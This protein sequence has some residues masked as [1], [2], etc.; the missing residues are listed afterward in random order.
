MN[1]LLLGCLLGNGGITSWTKKYIKDFPTDEFKLFPIKEALDDKVGV[2]EWSIIKRGIS[3]LRELRFIL[4]EI[5]DVLKED[6]MDIFHTT[7]SGSLGSF[8]D[9]IVGKYCHK[10]GMKTVM[11]CRYGCMPEMLKSRF[12]KFVIL[13]SMKYYDQVWV[14]DSQTFNALKQIPETSD[15]VRLTPNCIRVPKNNDIAAKKFNDIAFIANIYRQK[16]IFELIE[17]FKISRTNIKL[18]I[19]GPASEDIKVELNN[20]IS[21]HEDKIIY[22]GPLPN[23]E[24]VKFLEEMDGIA[25]PT[26]YPSEAFP[27]SI[28]EAMSRA[29]LVIST[30]RAAINDMLTA[31]DG[32]DC[33]IFVREQNIEDLVKALEWIDGHHN[34]ADE[35]CKKAYDKVLNCYDT[36]VVYDLYRTNYRALFN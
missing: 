2:E 20:A 17:A 22:H 15:K 9:Y 32:S 31:R 7:T 24:A 21:G 36:D 19:V 34:E 6:K 10:H 33:G 13:K 3:G 28:I 14:L 35:L 4:N 5:K 25:L 16:G 12:W 23:S 18:H 29:K 26:Y 27:I 1:I 8:R 11:H 30:R